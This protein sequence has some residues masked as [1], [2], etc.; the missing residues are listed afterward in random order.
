[1]ITKTIDKMFGKK[2]GFPSLPKGDEINEFSKIESH[3]K[4][5]FNNPRDKDTYLPNQIFWNS[6]KKEGN[7]DVLGLNA[8][9]LYDPNKD[10]WNS[11]EKQEENINYNENIQTPCIGNVVLDELKAEGIVIPKILNIIDEIN[12]DYCH[13][14]QLDE[15]KIK[16]NRPG[17]SG[18]INSLGYFVNNFEENVPNQAKELYSQFQEIVN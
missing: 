18:L 11:L 6:L 13:L 15:D 7:E 1:M 5:K 16:Y 10:F 14:G 8:K 9:D 17:F 12:E 3:S 2:K 4:R